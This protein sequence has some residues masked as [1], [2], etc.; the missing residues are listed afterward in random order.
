MAKHKY[1]MDEARIAEF[2]RQGRGT[3]AG[4]NYLP[5]LTIQDVPSEG[6]VHRPL[7]WKTGRVHHFL[8][9]VEFRHFL[10]FEW[11]E[12]VT[13]IRE[14]FPLNREKTLAIAEESGIPH[15]KDP[16][17]N[18]PIVMTSD[19]LVIA[20]AR[21][22]RRPIA[23][24][25]KPAIK[26]EDDRVI[27]KLEIERRYQEQAGVDWYISTER[28]LPEGKVQALDWM[29]SYYDLR[30]IIEPYPG[31]TR[32]SISRFLTVLDTNASNDKPLATAC[33]ELDEAHN[34]Q[35][36]T[37]LMIARHLLAR[38]VIVTDMDRKSIWNVPVCDLSIDE[39]ASSRLHRQFD[40]SQHFDDAA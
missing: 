40:V 20:G 22:R 38:K 28:E 34:T 15:P 33:A 8:S 23:F 25:I 9:D 7:G 19:F 17:T 27:E 3:G 37:Y 21:T 39:T 11:E 4:R 35:E 18:T 32:D 5:W 36:G 1:A 2:I 14:G 29:H 31:Y 13:D 12:G 24:A 6:R 10:L 30:D 26:L 16:R